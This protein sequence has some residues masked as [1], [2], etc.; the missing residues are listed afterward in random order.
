MVLGFTVFFQTPVQGGLPIAL[1][2]NVTNALSGVWAQRK[3]G[4]I[5]WREVGRLIPAALV[6]IALGTT[7]AMTLPADALRMIFGAFFLFMAGRMF[8]HAL[9]R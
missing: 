1:A 7:L 5:L 2:M 6:G 3:S 8:L 9:R 4:Q